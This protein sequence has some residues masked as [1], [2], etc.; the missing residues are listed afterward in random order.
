MKIGGLQRSSL[1]DYPGKISAIIFTQGCPFRC[2]YCHNPE[3]VNPDLFENSISESE[4]LSFLEKRRGQLDAVVI[5]GGE[6]TIHP[7][8]PDFMTKVKELEFLIK[9]D[10]NGSNPELLKKIIGDGLADYIAMDVKA[11]LSKYQKTAGETADAKKIEQSIRLIMGSKIPYEFRT[12]IVRSLLSPED[13]LEIGKLIKGAPLY[14]LQKF[15]ATKA[16]DPRFLAKETYSDEELE[17]M[18][19]KLEESVKKCIVR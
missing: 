14:A 6:P 17:E 16:L 10:T 3:L 7:D 19:K 5:T 18:R 2:P 15:R 1:I 8:L 9:L 12:T 13:I 11:P 4:I